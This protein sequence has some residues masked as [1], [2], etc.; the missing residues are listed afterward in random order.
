MH[1]LALWTMI[2]AAAPAADDLPSLAERTAGLE[3]RDGFVPFYWDARKGQLLLEVSRWEEDLLYGAG[4]AGGAGVIEASLDRG[5]LGDLAL[6]RFERVGP[7]VLLHQRQTAHRSGVADRERSR[8]VEESF[9]SAVLASLPVVAADGARVLV[10]ATAFLLADTR[11]TAILQQAGQG[12][13]RQ[14]VERSALHFERT[15]AFPL[16]TEIEA[17]LTFTSSDPPA[18]I[19][20]VLP[21]GRTMS[22]RVH[23]TFLAPPE[24]GY[25]P[26]PLDPRIGFL[27][28]AY[29]DFTAP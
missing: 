6:C 20:A 27:P 22:L 14:D 21:D 10:D 29:K 16:N 5:Q 12:S 1:V 19:V 3:R 13:W 9:P 11:V 24:P 23:H 25:A 2:L 26:R 8:A 28:L 7:R 18:S 17:V 15:G 4:L